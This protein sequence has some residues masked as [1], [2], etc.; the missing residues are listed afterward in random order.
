MSYSISRYKVKFSFARSSSTVNHKPLG[1]LAKLFMQQLI[2]S[3]L[4]NQSDVVFKFKNF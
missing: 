4:T 3:L 1:I 2:D